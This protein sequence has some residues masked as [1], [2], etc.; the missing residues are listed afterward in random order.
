MIEKSRRVTL[1]ALV[2]CCGSLSW[3]TL[4]TRSALAEEPRV[5]RKIEDFALNDAR[6]GAKSL[7]DWADSKLVVVAF[8]GTECPLASLYVPRLAE[9]A[10]RWSSKG[11][12][13][14]AINSNQQD[15]V[16]EVAAH[17][18]REGIPF[19]V[20]KDPAN[21]IADRFGAVRT[22]EIFVLD[23]TR[24]VRYCGRID[25]QYERTRARAVGLGYEKPK[26]NRDDLELALG[27]LLDGKPVTE[28][29]T[30][31]VG[32]LIG[33]VK[34][35]LPS[36]DVTYSNQVARVLQNRCVKCH[37]E[38][39]IGPFALT[40]YDE[41]V[42][43]AE[44]MREVIHE[45]RM[46]PWLA[47]P[48]HGD[49][50]NNP[51]LAKAEI[52]IID[53]WVENGCL[54]GNPADL[55]PV[56]EVAKGWGITEPDQIFYM[57]D[58]PFS[59]PAEGVVPYQTYTVDPGFTEDRWIK[60]AEV[61]VGSPAVVHHVIVFI[62]PPVGDY[63]SAPQIA[64][65]PGMTPLRLE[66]GLAFPVP[67]GSKL[68][69]Q[70]HYMTNGT[71]QQDRSY[72][73]FV[74]ADPKEVTHELLGGFCGDMA[75]K[76]PPHEPK[77]SITARKS[78]LKDTVLVGLFPHMHYRGKSFRYELELPNG[79]REVLL[80]VPRYDFNW[81]LWYLLKEPK[82]VPKGSRLTCTATFDNSEENPV[83]PD[84]SK[85]VTWGQQNWEEMMF[86]FYSTIKPR[87][88]AEVSQKK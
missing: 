37:Q 79:T 6:G 66:K 53:R 85:T 3:A 59:V 24:V 14:V 78:F 8:L 21:K 84:P 12:A 55:P 73:G 45:R 11:V 82:L 65:E 86:G 44:M 46:P 67:A 42:G 20:L 17:A 83:N 76:I 63:L 25:N 74:Y 57:S 38:G 10:G 28:P 1:A 60:Q 2:A 27:E 68:V 32:C 33:R 70:C 43:W 26:V 4:L 50:K 72:V 13:F 36:G 56:V 18:T 77:H 5:G 62:Q 87:A 54:E 35:P 51:S 7:K 19:P 41:V 29:T 15:S 9:I 64:Y 48:T 49:F 58:K 69:F 81:Q 40:S 80:D 23:S 30:E 31:A 34:R 88:S 52:A 61:K 75:F 39:Q 47:A 22:P 71:K 16:A